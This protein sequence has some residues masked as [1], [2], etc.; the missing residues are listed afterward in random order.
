MVFTVYSFNL[1]LSTSTVF[2]S[3]GR[4]NPSRFISSGVMIER[5]ASCV[6]DSDSIVSC[7]FRL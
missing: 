7:R 4:V 5:H 6:L 3:S 1:R 2:W